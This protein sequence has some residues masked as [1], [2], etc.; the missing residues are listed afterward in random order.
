MISIVLKFNSLFI[1]TKLTIYIVLTSLQS[2][3]VHTIG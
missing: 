1:V 2:K 3:R